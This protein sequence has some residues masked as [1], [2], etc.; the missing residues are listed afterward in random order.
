MVSKAFPVQLSG[1]IRAARHKPRGFLDE[2]NLTSF[3]F[4]VGS[5]EESAHVSLGYTSRWMFQDLVVALQ[6]PGPR[7]PWVLVEKLPA[8]LKLV[9]VQR[10]PKLDVFH[11]LGLLHLMLL[12]PTW[13]VIVYCFAE[14]LQQA[15]VVS[16]RRPYQQVG[17]PRG[18]SSKRSSCGLQ[19]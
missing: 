9:L 19:M 4:K 12:E 1:N 18:F 14:F 8:L 2:S 7:C 3:V 5:H 17:T 16:R 6:V 10:A 13:S 15:G 11:G